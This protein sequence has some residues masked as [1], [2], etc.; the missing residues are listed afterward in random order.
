MLGIVKRGEGMNSSACTVGM[1]QAA[2]E[3]WDRAI[4]QGQRGAR[5]KYGTAGKW[6]S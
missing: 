1:Q 3:E 2:G 6:G 4:A 5:V